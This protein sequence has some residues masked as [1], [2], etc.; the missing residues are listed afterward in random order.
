MDDPAVHP[1]GSPGQAVLREVPDR[2]SLRHSGHA[3]DQRDGQP[4]DGHAERL[5]R[6]PGHVAAQ[7]VGRRPH[8]E[9][10]FLRPTLHQ[11]HADLGSRIPRPDHQHLSPTVRFRVAVLRRMDQ[12]TLIGIPARPIRHERLA[13]E[14]GGYHDPT[15]AHAPSGCGDEPSVALSLDAVNRDAGSDVETEHARVVLQVANDPFAGDPRPL[16]PADRLP[17]EAREPADG[18]QVKPIVVRAPTRPHVAGPL[19]YQRLDAL[20]VEHRR[21]GEAGRSCPDYDRLV[22]LYVVGL[23]REAFGHAI[24]PADWAGAP[25]QTLAKRRAGV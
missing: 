17:G 2:E 4:P 11:V 8:R 22:L 20:L 24:P 3:V 1:S 13:V 9:H 19:E 25:A 12:L 6:E 5:R 7:D 23:L 10:D 14:A 18:M 21:R 16:A 15:R